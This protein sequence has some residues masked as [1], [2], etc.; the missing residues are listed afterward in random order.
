V[1]R[2]AFILFHAAALFSALLFTT[3][4]LAALRDFKAGTIMGWHSGINATIAIR[5]H[6][7][8]DWEWQCLEEQIGIGCSATGRFYWLQ[9]PYVFVAVLLIPPLTWCGWLVRRVSKRRVGRGFEVSVDSSA[10]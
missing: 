6:P 3:L 10:T 7:A 5:G 2:L 9:L 4:T 1:K 8:T